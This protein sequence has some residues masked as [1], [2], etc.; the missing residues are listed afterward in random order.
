RGYD[1]LRSLVPWLRQASVWRKRR[2][3]EDQAVCLFIFFLFV[4]SSDTSFH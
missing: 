2:V 1:D 4:E 3:S